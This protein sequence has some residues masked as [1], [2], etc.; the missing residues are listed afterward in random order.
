MYCCKTAPT[1]TDE[2]FVIILVGASY[3]GGNNRVSETRAS[4]IF[5]NAVMATSFHCKLF[6]L[7][8]DIVNNV[9]KGSMILEQSLTK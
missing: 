6:L 9:L 1:A 3:L 5:V 8:L 7:S 4:L 2:A